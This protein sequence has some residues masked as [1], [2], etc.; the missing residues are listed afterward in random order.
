M[1]KINE[2]KWFELQQP[3]LLWMAN[4]SYGRD[5]LCIDKNLPLITKIGKNFVRG[6]IDSKTLISDFRIGAKWSK[7]IRYRWKEFQE[8]AQFFKPRFVSILFPVLPQ[9]LKLYTTSTF[10]PDPHP[11]TNTVDGFA[12]RALAV[13]GETWDTLRAGAGN[14][15]SD[16]AGSGSFN[17]L[18]RAGTSPNWSDMIRSAYLFDTSPITDTDAVDSAVFSLY[19]TA[20]EDGVTG[21]GA[22]HV[23]AS[24]PASDTAVVDSDYDLPGGWGST[25]FG[26]I[27]YGSMSTDAYNDFTLN[28]SG[29]ANINLTGISKFGLRQSD[30]L[31]DTDPTH[32]GSGVDDGIRANYADTAD[33]TTDPKLVVVHVSTLGAI[34]LPLLGIQ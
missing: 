33:T 23:V 3:L 12:S 11:E 24:S 5:L 32:P 8:Y 17:D 7:V 14:F 9:P 28:A 34:M 13:A 1:K 16:T 22:A 20:V 15:S 18:L 21:S 29:E 6:K 26:S 27:A 30:E 19:V 10:F 25:S 2:N 4:S 31:N